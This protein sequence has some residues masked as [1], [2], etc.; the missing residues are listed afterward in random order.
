MLHSFAVGSYANSLGIYSEDHQECLLEI[1]DL[2]IGGITCLRWSPCGKMIWAGGRNTDSIVCWDIRHSR[3]E[4]G[5]VHRSLRTNQRLSFDLDPWGRFLVTGSQDGDL[6]V[7]DTAT[8]ER[9]AGKDEP[10][11]LSPRKR[12]LEEAK[13][14]INS[15][16]FHPFASLIITV[17]GERNY[18]RNDKDS[19]DDTE[20]EDIDEDN[21]SSG[22]QCR[23]VRC[24][25]LDI[26]STNQLDDSTS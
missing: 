17:T 23:L 5:R 26:I 1:R 7:Y 8:F 22:V 2:D 15:A 20:V 21:N 25:Q 14:C 13:N 18:R 10:D 4:L 12:K 9:I 3:T 24:N 11:I 16:A 19:D 6:L